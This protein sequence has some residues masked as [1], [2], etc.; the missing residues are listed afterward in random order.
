MGLQAL[1]F[2]VI[3]PSVCVCMFMHTTLCA[4]V[5]TLA[6][7]PRPLVSL[8]LRLAV[9][10][11]GKCRPI[12]LPSGT[13]SIHP[14]L[15][16]LGGQLISTHTNAKTPHVIWHLSPL[17]TWPS[18]DNNYRWHLPPGLFWSRYGGQ[19]SVVVIFRARVREGTNAQNALC[20]NIT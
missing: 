19:M 10:V 14:P 6:Y 18:P 7:G 9:A 1:C 5:H 20:I 4:Y 17:D 11:C 12:R 16:C 15:N 2:R 8:T 13:V 3:S